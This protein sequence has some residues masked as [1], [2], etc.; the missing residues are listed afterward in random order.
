MGLVELSKKEDSDGKTAKLNV[1]I[2]GS[3]ARE[4][5]LLWSFSKSG[6]ADK[7]YVAPGNGGTEKHN[8]NIGMEDLQDLAKFA[9]EHD[10]LTVVGSEKPLASGIVDY[11]RAK[12]LLIFGPTKDQAKLEWSKEYAKRLMKDSS[13]PTADFE[14]FTDSKTAIDYAE[15]KDWDV[16]VKA[17][18]LAEGKGVFVCSSE[19]EAK[20][21]IVGILDKKR[22][23]DAGSSIIIEEKLLGREVSIFALCDGKNAM[24]IGT[25]VDHKQLLDGGEGPN[26]GG[27]GA[28]SPASELGVELIDWVM[29][30][31]VKQIVE[32]TG[33]VGFLYVGLVMSADGLKVLE[34]NS[35]LGDPEAEVILPRL[36]FD[37]LKEIYSVSKGGRVGV[38]PDKVFNGLQA[39]CVV[40]CSE[41]Y[42]F[43]YKDKL[44]REIS[45]AA[46]AS[47]EEDTIV[48]HAG[49][50]LEG[51]KLVTSGG[52]VL[53]ATAVAPNLED[54][55]G[56]AYRAVEMISF[57]GEQHRSDI[58]GGIR[59]V[60]T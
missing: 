11:F 28:Y 58:A 7:V 17:D 2:V 60:K 41:G 15:S 26:T 18:G 23:G 33:F 27:M 59:K 34:F 50:R 42:P 24:F 54:A 49:T 39:A 40:M 21:A 9:Q 22:F 38:L 5:A 6:M 35:R 57:K 56:K 19:E 25:A 51:R 44:G 36:K 3:G 13:I 10:C 30:T 20:A 46:D 1:L 29:E 48:F 45:G 32:K 4:H 37:L 53:C 12:G 8:V 55:L 31:T 47:T 14:V 52:R 16:V 43:D